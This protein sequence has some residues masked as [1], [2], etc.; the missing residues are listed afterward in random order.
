MYII[1]HKRRDIAKIN[2]DICFPQFSKNERK[3]ILKENFKSSGIAFFEMSVSWFWPK[4][5]LAKLTKIEGLDELKKI[6]NEGQ[7]I[8]LLALHFTTLEIGAALL[9]QKIPID[10]MYR[11]HKNKV[12]D[13]IQRKGRE[14]HNKDSIAFEREDL[15]GMIRSLR[16][17]R[18]VWYAP[19]QDYGRKQSIFVPFFGVQAATV[20]ATTTFARLGNAKV[21]PFIQKR[22]PNNEGYQLIIYPP[23]NDFPSDQEEDCIRINRWIE[24]AISENPEQY[25]WA[26]RRFKTRPEGEKKIY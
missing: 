13:Y 9:G 22:L 24:K 12:F 20:P 8:I 6:T 14:R 1:S 4:K 10:G 5:R 11:M 23:L 15:R 26:H 2:I 7:G 21:C 3:K 16:N 17:G 19:D 25:L 18:I